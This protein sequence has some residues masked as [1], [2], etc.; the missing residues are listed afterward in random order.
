ML[1]GDPIVQVY[2]GEHGWMS[3]RS[4]THNVPETAIRE[5]EASLKRDLLTVLLAAHDGRLKTRLLPDVPSPSGARQHVVEVSGPDF[6]PLVLYVDPQTSLVTKQT[7]VAG[8]PG[9][10][11]VEELFSDYRTIDGLLIAFN[12]EVRRGGRRVVLRRVTDIVVN[13]PIEQAHFGRPA[14]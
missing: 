10:P 9:S 3:D 14:S 7:Y 2:D 4:G 6:E 12:A 11:F 8:A 1:Q 5:L 13:P